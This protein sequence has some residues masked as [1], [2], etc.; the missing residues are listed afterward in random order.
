MPFQ[1]ESFDAAYGIEATCHAPRLEHVYGEVFRILKPGG[2]F[3]AYEWCT[4]EKY[5]EANLEIKKI[6]HLV[7]E[8]NSIAKFYTIPQCLQ[9]Q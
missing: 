4:T 8:G 9:V 5:E 7:E 3:S 2:L 1:S 6:V